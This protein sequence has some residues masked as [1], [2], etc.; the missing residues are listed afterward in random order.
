MEAIKSSTCMQVAGLLKV[1][2]FEPEDQ[3]STSVEY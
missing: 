1:A 2:I 3:E